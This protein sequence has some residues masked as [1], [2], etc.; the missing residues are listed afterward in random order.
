[1]E[2]HTSNTPTQGAARRLSKLL[3]EYKARDVL[4]LLSGGSALTLLDR[5]DTTPMSERVTISLLDERYT[6]DESVSNFSQLT[7]TA[8]Y[9][10]AAKQHVHVID[11]RPREGEGLLDTAKRFD[12]ALKHWHITHHNGVVLAT[13][14]VGSDGHT[15]GILP[16]PNNP[17]TFEERFGAKHRCAVGY[18]VDPRVNPHTDRV[19]V[20]S[21]Y[22]VRHADHAIVYAT[23]EEKRTALEA[24]LAE[25]GSLHVTPARILCT[26]RDVALYTDLTLTH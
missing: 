18:H 3:D 13:M 2:L 14:G 5:V 1:M 6:F 15:A 9:E 21:T 26:M 17:E 8:F 19:T 16:F 22:L 20:T 25:E 24:V 7:K 12:L 10:R 11:P 23:G 4:L